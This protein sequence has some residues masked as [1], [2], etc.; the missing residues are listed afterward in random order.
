[1]C[2]CTDR[3]AERSAFARVAHS[4]AFQEGLSVRESRG[5][6]GSVVVPHAVPLEVSTAHKQVERMRRSSIDWRIEDLQAVAKRHGIEWRQKGT[7]HVYFRHPDGRVLSVP[8]HGVIK[9]IS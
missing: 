8:D 7:S 5:L 1:M 3:A 9:S 2:G 4:P 6:N